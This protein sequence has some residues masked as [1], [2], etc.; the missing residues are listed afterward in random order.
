MAVLLFHLLEF[1]QLIGSQYGAH[2]GDEV[3]LHLL[4]DLP[5]ILAGAL[6][7][8]ALRLLVVEDLLHLRLLC[9]REIELTRQLVDGRLAVMA[10]WLLGAAG[11]RQQECGREG[12]YQGLHRAP[13]SRELAA[14]RL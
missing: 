1:L 9:R 7:L 6:Q 3:A 2:L 14:A 10:V 4:H 11:L 12:A 8:L 13:Q 5:S